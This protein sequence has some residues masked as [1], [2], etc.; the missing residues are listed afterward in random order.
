MPL[1]L[2]LSD[3]MGFLERMLYTLP[4]ILIALTLH[5]WAHGFV[6]WRLGDPTAKVMGRLSLNPLH[7][8]DP[9]GTLM[10]VFVGIGWARPVPVN[11][12]YFKKPRRDDL[13]VSLAGVTMNFLLFAVSTTVLL[14]LFY[15]SPLSGDSYLADFLFSLSATNAVLML[16]N[17]LPVPPLDGYHVLNDLV[18]KRS[19]F[20]SEQVG[21]IGYVVLLAVMFTGILDK[22]LNFVINGMYSGAETLFRGVCQ[23][24]GLL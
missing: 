1:Q 4:A 21:R 19:L 17:L 3:P 18:L 16:F 13:L 10:L 9:I 8:L 2:L 23:W 14:S 24:F 7:H 6:A 5:E 20:A 22:A 11:P 12:R 15:F